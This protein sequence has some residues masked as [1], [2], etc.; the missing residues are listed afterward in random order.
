MNT[1]Q[2]GTN[3]IAPTVSLKQPTFRSYLALARFDH[4]TKHVFIIPGFVLAYIVAHGPVTSPIPSIIIGLASATLIAAANYVINEWL[5]RSFDAFHP[6]KSKRAAVTCA[7]SPRWV[8]TEYVLLALT[9]LSLAYVIGG[10]FF[11]AAI[12]FVLSGVVY[13]VEPVRMKD[14]A[15]LDVI[16]ESVNSPI[17]L[18]MGWGMVSP[19]TL[20]PASLLIAFWFGGA[21]L[22]A[23]KRLSEYRS[24]VAAQKPEA[25]HKYRSSFR[26]YRS[27]FRRYTEEG[28]LVS[29]LLYAT[30]S[31]FAI[32]AFLIQ[33]RIEY[34]LALPFIAALFTMYFWIAL[35]QGSAVEHPERLFQSRRLMLATALTILAGI[36]ASVIDLPQL[37]QFSIP[38]LIHIR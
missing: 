5:D 9:G 23:A 7:L 16:S 34:I 3:F 21:F 24:L 19:A 35:Q 8:Y 6:V 36:A 17:R 4:M 28:L 37:K 29:C 11:V 1:K 20:P 10:I 14:K 12:A 15:Y 18:S 30:L 33:Y 13:N 27:S 38:H 2:A 22:M 31:A 32:T 25:L 26:Q